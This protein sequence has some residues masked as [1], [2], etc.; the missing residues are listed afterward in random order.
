M[1]EVE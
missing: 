1:G